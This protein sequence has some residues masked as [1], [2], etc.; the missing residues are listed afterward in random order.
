MR[1]RIYFA[2]T[3]AMRFTSHLDLHR[4][5]ER[6]IRRSG[7]PLA[8]TLGFRPHPRINLG[9]AL[10][11]GFT[12]QDEVVDV[13]LETEIPIDE[14]ESALRRAVPPGIDIDGVEG[15]DERAPALQSILGASEYQVTL[16]EPLRDLDE[17]VRQILEAESL[18]RQRRGKDYDLRPL[19]YDLS[20]LP[21]DPEGNQR[22]FILLSSRENATGRPEEVILA[23]GGDP[24]TAR[25]H[26]TRLVVQ[27]E[28]VTA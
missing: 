2:K 16:L 25:V 5:W 6:T 8:Y 7:L 15:I 1:I 4:T 26:R 19:I 22:L 28:I 17:Q 14:I 11:L 23:L 12:S 18:R 20:R 9:S 13:W 10:P 27:P 21:D 3:E 24:A